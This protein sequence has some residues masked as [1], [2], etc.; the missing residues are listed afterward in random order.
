MSEGNLNNIN[1]EK[2]VSFFFGIYRE[3]Q[4]VGSKE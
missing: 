1:T 3:K 2:P 4:Q